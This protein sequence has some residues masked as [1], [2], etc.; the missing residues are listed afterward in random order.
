[1]VEL[2]DEDILD[3]IQQEI[4]EI[5]PLCPNCRSDVVEPIGKTFDELT[6]LRCH[7]CDYIFVE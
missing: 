2:G 4:E 5:G 6:I 1:M 3:I 7:Q